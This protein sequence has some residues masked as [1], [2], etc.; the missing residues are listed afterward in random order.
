MKRRLNKEDALAYRELC[1]KRFGIKM[2]AKE[3]NWFMK[4]LAALL[5]FNK[6]FLTGYRTTIGKTVYWTKLDQYGENPYGDVRVLFHE[7]QHAADY[8]RAP[9]FFIV[10]YLL[11]QILAPVI[12]LLALLA[13]WFDGAWLLALL[14]LAL[15]APLPALGRTIAEMRG[16]SCGLAFDLW[17][18]GRV[19]ESTY[20]RN[21]RAFT[22]SAY[23]WMWPFGKHVVRWLQ[24][25][26]ENIRAGKLTLVQTE[27]YSFMKE[28][29]L[30]EES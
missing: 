25:K 24:G 8:A 15:L 30:L 20:E 6:N 17:Y 13:I 27:T 21:R 5:F 19:E 9:F 4:F 11:P 3:T 22:S 28:R 2:V 16:Y 12:A 18:L 7:T 14:G 10:G 29:G 23:Y 1:E 26:L